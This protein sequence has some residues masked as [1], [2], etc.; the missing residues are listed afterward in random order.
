MA[1]SLMSFK[2]TNL[3]PIVAA[4]TSFLLV[5]GPIFNCCRLNE[6]I[7]EN[8]AKALNGIGHWGIQPGEGS[9]DTVVKTHPGCHGHPVSGEPQ[10]ASA[11]FED[12]PVQWRSLETCL[13]ELDALPKALLPSLTI[14]L[15]PSFG[16]SWIYSV[17]EAPPLP[18]FEKPR[19]QNK[20]SPP[21][22]LLTLRLL[23]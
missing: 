14:V 11:T 18:R 9:D 20:S 2:K 6:S 13:S 3:L 1:P 12:A 15:D 17:N 22:Y 16:A 4:V 19:P 5:A 21:V 8:V 23:V 7:T 10:V